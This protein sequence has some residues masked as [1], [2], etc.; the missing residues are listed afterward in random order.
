M[1]L[2][3]NCQNKRHSYKRI[4]CFS[5]TR[6][7]LNLLFVVS[8]Y[9]MEWKHLKTLFAALMNLIKTEKIIINLREGRKTKKKQ[10]Q[11]N[12]KRNQCSSFIH[13][14]FEFTD[15]KNVNIFLKK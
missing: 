4:L 13:V 15:R 5:Y 10:H 9:K 1:L 8:R 14:F 12:L 2:V 11:E 7:T 3:Y 6:L